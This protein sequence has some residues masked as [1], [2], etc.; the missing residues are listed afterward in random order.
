M[1]HF[2]T[3]EPSGRYI[4]HYGDFH[5]YS[6]S[7]S[8][9][10]IQPDYEMNIHVPAPGE[11]DFYYGPATGGLMESM[12]IR[13]TTPGELIRASVVNPYFKKR[14]LKMKGIPVEDALLV[15]ERIN[16]FHSASHSI[17]FLGAVEDAL[18]IE[19]PDS[20]S[21]SRMLMLE[22]E[23]IRSNLEVLK[24]VCE[25]SG[26]GV[27]V[28][29][30]GYLREKISRIIS[31]A[32]GHRFFFASGG[33]ARAGITT[34]GM[35]EP[36]A[37]IRKEFAR[38][39]DGLQESKIFLNRLQNN[40]V[41]RSRI[42]LGP[43]ARAAGLRHDARLDSGTLPY[44]DLGFEPEIRDEKDASGRLLVR[45]QE[46][47]ASMDLIGSIGKPANGGSESPTLRGEGE[48]TARVESPQGDLF[49]YVKVNDGILED[50]WF[51]TPS[52]LNIT[53]FETSMVG[54]IFPD[55]PLN[56]ESFGIW[57]SEMGVDI[58]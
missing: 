21:R 37:G 57:I 7:V 13:L 24:R 48:G 11:F 20:V 33:I 22:L 26:F 6:G 51:V 55:L 38:I 31:R 18:G 49:Y 53:A 15:V 1:A 35:E 25:P 10:E 43:T 14:A 42:L 16:G 3:G 28:S 2:K 50:V 36:L 41:T 27:P 39:F 46:I 4:G 52:E 23:R 58:R 9:E 54:N 34:D 45:G 30:I 5:V 32:S 47:L 44:G 19:V 12:G 8:H 40:G 17:A 56:W 29:Q